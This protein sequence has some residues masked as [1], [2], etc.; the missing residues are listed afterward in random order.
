MYRI[1]KSTCYHK[2]FDL[3]HTNST[4]NRRV[5]TTCLWASGGFQAAL[6]VVEWLKRILR[7]NKGLICSAVLRS[8]KYSTAHAHIHKYTA[9]KC[10]HE[11][12]PGAKPLF[13]PL[14]VYMCV[15]ISHLT[16]LKPYP[17]AGTLN[18]WYTT[19]RSTLTTFRLLPVVCALMY[20]AND[21]QWALYI[22]AQSLVFAGPCGDLYFL[23]LWA[24]A[25]RFDCCFFVNL[26]IANMCRL[27]KDVLSSE[28][29]ITYIGIFSVFWPSDLD[30]AAAWFHLRLG[31][32]FISK[33]NVLCMWWLTPY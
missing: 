17:S 3:S 2:T 21:G 1:C 32:M 27:M 26:H 13:A 9:K 16:F 29:Y 11:Q 19:H 23:T 30:A 20:S 25:Y 22:W 28:K 5:C 33:E 24:W 31:W 6:C 8:V 4:V 14:T 10:L 15:Q 12:C 7:G 18:N